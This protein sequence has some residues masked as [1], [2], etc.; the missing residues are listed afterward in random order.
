MT[1][2][3]TLLSLLI[4]PQVVFAGSLP[5]FSD[6]PAGL[7]LYLGTPDKSD[8]DELIELSNSDKW[9]GQILTEDPTKVSE[10]RKVLIEKGNG[11][12]SV[13]S[14]NGYN[15]PVLNNLINK[16]ICADSATVPKEEIMRIVAP[17]GKVYFNKNGQWAAE[18]KAV[19][20][21]IDDWPMAFYGADNNA[22]SF[23]EMVGPPKHIQW[24]SGPSWTRSHEMIS[25]L[26]SMVSNNGVL[27][28][29]IDEG[30]RLS[31]ILPE[32]W[33]LVAQDAFNGKI[34]WKL[35]LETWHNHL[36]PVKSGPA[37]LQRRLIAIGDKLY[38]PLAAGAPLSEVDAFSG[39][40]LRS[41][42]GTEGLEE[43]VFDNGSLYALTGE[44]AKAQEG[45]ELSNVEV[46]GAAGDATG[47][48]KFENNQKNKI[49]QIEQESG[50]IIWSH[51]SAIVPNTMAINHKGVFF[52]NGKQVVA[53]NPD[54]SDKWKGEAFELKK[55]KLGTAT[56]PTLLCQDDVVLATLGFDFK[57]GKIYAHHI[58]TGKI[59]WTSKH[60][61]SGHSSQDDLFVIN[62]LAWSGAIA[63][64]QHQGG[65]YDGHHLKSG[66]VATS[67]PPN[68]KSNFWFHQRCYRSKATAKYVIPAA[69]GTEYVDLQN[70][71]WDVHHWLRGACLNGI[72][73]A[74]GMT[75]VTPHPCAC[76]TE[77]MLRGFSGLVTPGMQKDLI[78][79]KETPRLIKGPAFNTPL[80]EQA[81]GWN[82][83]R[84]G[85]KRLS[86]N[87]NAISANLSPQW[88]IKIA[89]GEKLT[90]PVA[91]NGK[92]YVAAVRKNTLYA[93][94]QE[95]G[96][97]LWSFSTA[98]KIDSSPSLWKGRVIFGSADG[99]LY[100][101]NEDNGELVWRFRGTKEDRQM[102]I[103][104]RVESIWPI[105]GSNPIVDGTIYCLAGR[106][107]FLDGGL[108][109]SLIDAATGELKSEVIHGD[110]D[111]KD[112]IQVQLK[113]QGQKMVPGNSDILS[114]DG[115]HLYMN[116]QRIGLDGKRI[117]KEGHG[118]HY[119]TLTFSRSD[120]EGEGTHLFAPVGFLD[121]SWHHR[122]FWIY[123]KGAGSGWGGWQKPGKYVPTGRLMVV[124]PDHTVYSF[125]RRP[126][127]FA[128]SHIMEYMISSS[129]GNA[130]KSGDWE[131]TFL[132][133]KNKEASITNW[134]KNS[135]LPIEK[136]SSLKFNWRN[137]EPGLLGRAMAG[138]GDSL[139]IAGP[140][141]ILDET[142]LY[143]QF[144]QP[145]SIKKIQAQQDAIDGSMGAILRTVSTTDGKTVAEY[146]LSAPP[147]FDGMA[148]ANGKIFIVLQDG[149]L[150]CWQATEE[151][152]KLTTN[153]QVK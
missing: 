39:K 54:G 4:L 125:G 15:L 92:V 72:L 28:Y 91:N 21:N 136:L 47:K 134:E 43:V 13:R 120:Q 86:Y 2:W 102:A 122:S 20:T 12:L 115:K 121:D 116:S 139:F 106:T 96:K 111:E 98:G 97:T 95:T 80:K 85:N 87:Q 83:F 48:Y 77:S 58:D 63:R 88:E 94:D 153:Q 103:E 114:F 90:Q 140:P 32:K 18:T 144:S 65:N 14:Y 142:K 44:S 30:S 147:V 79:V 137:T 119:K 126:E 27:Y 25:S 124:K 131:K 152:T 52:H 145:E 53:L 75:Y 73:P 36:W 89:P 19:P 33:R 117:Y 8:F 57:D 105:H 100:C 42:A 82:N 81:Q 51:D 138:A 34:L 17:R 41:F 31:A 59:I 61:S 135:K 84:Y 22:V 6:S 127:F 68:V 76:N 133:I 141:D 16:V 71:T 45:Y 112:G 99:H 5:D 149:S 40:V 101:L 37:Q 29:I 55:Y 110:K 38:L 129:Q 130:Y 70:K 26:T 69:T 56:T 78:E 109:L 49:M 143:G 62:G 60:H 1:K 108:R 50:K 150:V 146:K 148:A 67:F 46:W 7:V 104:G 9:N 3:Q 132:P 23:D 118:K 10:L 74:N 24:R 123:G 64:I 107:I 128:Q 113:N 66:E 93:L 35:D 11:S 151:S